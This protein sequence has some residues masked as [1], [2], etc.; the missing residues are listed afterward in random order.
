MSVGGEVLREVGEVVS[1]PNDRDG[2]YQGF[3]SGSRRG[4]TTEGKEEKVEGRGVRGEGKEELCGG[5][6]TERRR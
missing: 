5:W 2:D 6:F 3:R 4:G 1:P